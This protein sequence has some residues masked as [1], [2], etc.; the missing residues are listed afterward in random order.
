MAN[1]PKCGYHLKLT[2]WK[3]ECPECG[4][5]VVYYQ[6]EDRLREDADKAE[7]EQAKFQ[8]R[9]DRLKASVYGS[10][11]AIIRI[12]CIL[13]PILCLLLPLASITTSLPFGTSTTT[14]N[15][16]AI[17]NFISD[18]DIGLLIKLFSSTVLGKD[19]IFFAASFV[20]LLLAVVCML[21]N[22]VFL[23]MSF[24]K[25]GLRRNVTTNI[26]GI[27]FTVASA[28]CFSLSNKG[29]TSDVAGLYSGSLK[30]GSFVVIF[31]FI[32]LIVV[33]LLFK[34][35]KVEVNYTDVSELL[36]PYHERKAYREEQERLAA[37]SDETRAAEALK[38]A[39]E[40][41]KAIHEM[42]EQHNK[43]HKKK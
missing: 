24:G 21:L 20:L 34:I 10:P 38:E 43:H 25:R 23:V 7:L 31:A 19:F 36:L 37:E 29:F 2:D 41:L 26:I 16:I 17:Y 42:N 22:L 30:W 40:R 9:M 5:N 33:N 27:I 1:C 6:I 12:V 35:L 18:L 3:P 15:L 4:V 8:P 28:V 39:E 13:A 11:L 32:L 14:V